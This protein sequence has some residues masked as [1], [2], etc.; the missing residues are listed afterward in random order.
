[1]CSMY[2]QTSFIQLKLGASQS[3]EWAFMFIRNFAE[4]VH[5]K[6]GTAVAS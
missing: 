1:M 4:S 2:S 6:L 3:T 5:G